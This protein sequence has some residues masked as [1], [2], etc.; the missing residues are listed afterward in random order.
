[1]NNS[2][3]EA[4]ITEIEKALAS[5]RIALP[6][7]TVVPGV[8]QGTWCIGDDASRRSE[9]V[10]ALRLGIELGMKLIDTAEMYG[11]GRSETV[12]GEAV[13]GIRDKVFLVSKVYPHNA[14]LKRIAKSCEDSLKRL[15]T[16][17]LDL[18]LLHW[19]G[20]VPLE[21]TVQGMERLVEQGKIARWGVS[22]FDTDDMKELSRLARGT[23]CVTNQVLYHLGSRGIEFDLL[24]WQRER[25]MPIMAY[26][27]LAQ[28]GALR[29]GLV[30][31]AAVKA[32]A[33]AHGAS[34]LQILLAWCVREGD[35]IAIPKASSREHVLQNAAAGLIRLSA[36]ELRQLDEAF[37]GPARKMPLDI[38]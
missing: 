15:R 7:G 21:E 10:K 29:K 35:V 28:A 38:I 12:V 22:N 3:N 36:D 33:A 30:Q 2:V 37:P 27:P 26:S 11:E 17:H 25:Q 24:P 8:G 18:Y 13:R 4:S 5:S 23:H 31:N 19:R 20:S 1:M 32:I 14:G 6:D 9:E 16:D 34:P